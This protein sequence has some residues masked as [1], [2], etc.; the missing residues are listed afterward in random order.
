M[1]IITS[2]VWH[3]DLC[4]RQAREENGVK[5]SEW[6][7][8]SIENPQCE[9]LFTDKCVCSACIKLLMIRSSMK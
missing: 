8:I 9:R 5:P 2:K 7:D 3:C 4:G 6:A 1:P